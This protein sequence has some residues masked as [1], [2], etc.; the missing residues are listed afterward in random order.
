MAGAHCTLS[1]SV[2][3]PLQVFH[4]PVFF[5]AAGKPDFWPSVLPQLLQMLQAKAAQAGVTKDP[6]GARRGRGQRVQMGKFGCVQLTGF[7]S[8]LNLSRASEV[9]VPGPIVL[10]GEARCDFSTSTIHCPASF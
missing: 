1:A 7:P 4:F 9:L 3:L 10:G 2:P 5:P 6:A 8:C